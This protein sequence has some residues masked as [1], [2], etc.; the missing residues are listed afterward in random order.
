MCIAEAG[1]MEGTSENI[2]V[3]IITGGCAPLINGL[4]EL[5][6]TYTDGSDDA[7]IIAVIV[8]ATTVCVI[9][10]LFLTTIG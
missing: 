2:T 6:Y 1:E 4:H 8:C 7:Y 5:R 10:L 9:L 3:T